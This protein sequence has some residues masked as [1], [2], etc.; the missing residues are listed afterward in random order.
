LWRIP[1]QRRVDHG[2]CYSS[3]EVGDD[4]AFAILTA[5]LA[6]RDF[7]EPRFLRFACGRPKAFWTK[8]CVAL[9]SDALEPLE[10]TKLHLVQTGVMRLLSIFPE[11][12][13]QPADAAEYN[14]VTITE[15]Q[16]VRD[17]LILHYKLTNRNDSA[18]WRDRAAMEIPESLH[19]KIDLFRNTGRI[20]LHE[21]GHFDEASWIAVL[22]GQGVKP[23]SFDPLAEMSDE[24]QAR[25]ALGQMSRWIADGV[26]SMP[27]HRDFLERY[28]AQGGA[29]P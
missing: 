4:E 2:H 14:R 29:K 20:S 16:Q 12:R 25:D 26:G 1:L 27:S 3:D 28:C 9:P 13:Y 18:F 10:A 11:R 5:S 15:Y 17:F 19:R 24:K 22:L 21:D 8:N 6:G 23:K 7:T